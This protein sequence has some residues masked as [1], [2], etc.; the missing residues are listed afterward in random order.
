MHGQCGGLVWVLQRVHDMH[1]H[2]RKDTVERKLTRHMLD[3][4]ADDL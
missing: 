3:W 1:Q 2:T 4:C